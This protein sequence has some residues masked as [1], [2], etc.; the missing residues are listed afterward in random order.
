MKRPIRFL[1]ISILFLFLLV[2]CEPSSASSTTTSGKETEALTTAA[3][4]VE[5]SGST[6][7][8]SET[9]AETETVASEPEETA[10]SAATEPKTEAT[11]LLETTKAPET[12]PPSPPSEQPTQP[13]TQPPT[14][15]PTQPK[16][17][18][19][20][21][22]E[23]KPTEHVHSWSDWKQTAAPTCSAD[24]W[25]TRV[26][27]GCGF[28]ETRNISAT[29]NHS[30]QETAPTCTQE[31]AKTCKVC[32]KKETVP[33]LGHD[34]VHSDEVGHWQNL[35]TCRCGAQFSSTDDWYA[36]A[37]A[38]PDLDY[39]DAHAGYELHQT[40]VVDTPAQ[41]V[42]SRCGTVK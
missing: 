9:E 14:E 13:A 12:E 23:P 6:S 42:C 37:T 8:P 22:T 3:T 27:T 26:C 28:S 18:E 25:Q 7:E 19:P 5:E 15:P 1:V 34:W 11:Q 10:E 16:P 30:W 31:G 41:D 38:S 39:A 2:G 4:S 33:A 24:G 21:P 17:T 32:G 29:G 35:I 40:W 20:K 36:H